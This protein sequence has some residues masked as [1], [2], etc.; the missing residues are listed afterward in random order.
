MAK[1]GQIEIKLPN[2]VAFICALRA[3]IKSLAR[4][5]EFHPT[6]VED[7]ELVVDELCNNAMEHGSEPDSQV[8][9]I[10]SVKDSALDILV[11]DEGKGESSSHFLRSLRE[12]RR[13]RLSPHSERGYGIYIVEM[14]S[15]HFCFSLNQFGGI[16][17]RVIFYKIASGIDER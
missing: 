7:I 9:V 12:I 8:T 13:R 16:D 3:F 14:L 2:N 6:R 11:R 15:D 17:A 5:L 1:E 10:I 4:R